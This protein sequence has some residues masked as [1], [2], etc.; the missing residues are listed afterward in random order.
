MRGNLSLARQTAA[1]RAQALEELGRG[2]RRGFNADLPLP[3]RLA[4][5]V[6]K[7]EE[8]PRHSP[9]VSKGWSP[10]K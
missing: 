10:E 7:I 5:L 1:Y 6:R 2:L 4:E 3:D 9:P 8:L